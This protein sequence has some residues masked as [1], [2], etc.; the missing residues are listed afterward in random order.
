MEVLSLNLKENGKVEIEIP[1]ELLNVMN[2]NESLII[3]EHV[4]RLTHVLVDVM[5]RYMEVEEQ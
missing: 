3:T 2:F 4:E 5:S 1:E